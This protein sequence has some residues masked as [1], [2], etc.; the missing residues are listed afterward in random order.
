MKVTP[1][2]KLYRLLWLLMGLLFLFLF[3]L[4]FQLL[5][6]SHRVWAGI[7]L[8]VTFGVIIALYIKTVLN[9]F[10]IEIVGDKLQVLQFGKTLGT[11]AINKLKFTADQTDAG[12]KKYHRI[13]FEINQQKIIVTN[14]E[15][16]GFDDF[17]KLLI[18]K[19]R[20][21]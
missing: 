4:V 9:Y 6:G 16:L 5:L 3:W 18:K 12:K 21:R 8:I 14:F 10:T 13:L 17:H 11:E 15:H 19:K 1:N 20:I 7:G 2:K